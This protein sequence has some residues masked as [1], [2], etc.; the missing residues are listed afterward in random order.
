MGVVPPAKGR[1]ADTI[2]WTRQ[3]FAHHTLLEVQP[4]T[5]RT[6]QIRVHL[7][8]IGCPVVGD[9][10]YGRK[11]P[12]LPLD[13]QFLHACRLVLRLPGQHEASTFEAPLPPELR[14][15]LRDLEKLER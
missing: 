6:H 8:F 1:Q 15:V 13:R 11:R 10:V 4:L 7:A 14:S 9:V 3:A 5:G 12:T 2:Y